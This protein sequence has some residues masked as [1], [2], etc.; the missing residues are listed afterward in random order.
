MRSA[1]GSNI[2]VMMIATM[3]QV[4]ETYTGMPNGRPMRIP[5]R[6][7]RSPSRGVLSATFG[8]VRGGSSRRPKGV[9]DESR[10]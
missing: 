1:V 2:T 10:S 4:G 7:G 5:G 8:M 9:S 6:V 3:N